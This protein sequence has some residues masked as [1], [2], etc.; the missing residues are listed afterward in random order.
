MVRLHIALR[1]S[2]LARILP[3]NHFEQLTLESARRKELLKLLVLEPEC[4]SWKIQALKDMVLREFVENSHWLGLLTSCPA[5][6][7]ATLAE[8]TTAQ[9]SASLT[10]TPPFSV[11]AVESAPRYSRACALNG[12]C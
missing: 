10:S 2:A 8:L 12:A 5:F 11:I 4:G 6:C 1:I 9:A 7:R 3:A